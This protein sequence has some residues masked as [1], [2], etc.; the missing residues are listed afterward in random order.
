MS[1]GVI[2]LLHHGPCHDLCAGCAHGGVRRDGAPA[3]IVYL[4]AL[5][6]EDLAE[7][8][9]FFGVR[10][11]VFYIVVVRLVEHTCAV[12]VAVGILIS[13]PPHLVLKLS[14]GGHAPDTH[15]ARHC[16]QHLILRRAQLRLVTRLTREVLAREQ[17]H[18]LMEATDNWNLGL[19]WILSD[20]LTRSFCR[21]GGRGAHH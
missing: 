14:L 4:G 13:N 10:V 7:D 18:L 1:E 8:V 21:R 17:Q 16:S 5:L 11:I 12:V 15:A 9:L 2:L 6:K 20:R 3:L 19:R